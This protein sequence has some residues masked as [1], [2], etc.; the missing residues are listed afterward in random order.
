MGFLLR[1]IVSRMLFPVPLIALL[2]VVALVA[3]WRRRRRVAL[4]SGGAAVVLFLIAGCE[5]L[6][7]RAL[8]QL[9]RR[10]AEYPVELPAPRGDESLWIVV[11][12][13]GHVNRQDLPPLVTKGT[14]G[15]ARVA[16]GVELA[17]RYPAAPVIFTGGSVTDAAT[18]IS[19]AEAG[20]AA[21]RALGLPPE[22]IH[23]I[24]HP[25]DTAS[26][27]RAIAELVQH[28]Q[29][30]GWHGAPGLYPPTNILL[31]T[32]A[33]HLPRAVHFF[34]RALAAHPTPPELIPLPAEVRADTGPYTPW[35]WL[36]SARALEKSTLVVYEV[37]GLVWMTVRR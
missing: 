20:A 12:G 33:S 10:H 21:A 3:A 8:W 31:I 6:A 34:H 28:T 18:T 17:R 15:R 19:T 1:K 2:G 23:T 26:E 4:V 36:P 5:P 7:D 13:S 9:E 14:S 22:R 30:E 24:P 32:S 35:E 11:L 37:L 25:L 16:R 27:A 29:A